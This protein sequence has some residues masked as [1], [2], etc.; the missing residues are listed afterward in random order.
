MAAP[1]LHESERVEITVLVDN[2]T[3]TFLIESTDVM[4]RPKAFPA[5]GPLA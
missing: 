3:D 4:K 5:V 2:Y 1:I